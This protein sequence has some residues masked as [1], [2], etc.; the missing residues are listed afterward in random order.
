M[1][2][3]SPRWTN[4]GTVA[5]FETGQPNQVLLEFAKRF[6]QAGAAPRCLDIGCGAARNALPLAALG[7]RVSA[8]DL[9]APMLEGA[10]R[11][12]AGATPQPAVDLVR[13]PMA[14]LPFADAGFDLIVAHGIWNLAR[15]GVEFRAA[16]AEA[17]RVARPGAGLFVFTFSR[18]TLGPAAV[19]DA[20]ESFVFSSWN[21]EPQCFLT[22]PE[23]L[24][25]LASAG[26]ERADPGPLTEYNVPRPGE[27]RAGGP[28]VI[29]EGTF[30]K[31]STVRP[32]SLR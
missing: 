10:K 21:G 9:S 15:S 31:Q 11:R 26:F 8:T 2:E 25:E 29:Y 5:G 24:R 17:A 6:A 30:V 14:P 19:P 28:P 16:V 13:A 27:L 12:I 3:V 22:E 18:H 20:G 32:V 23:L 7:F 4:A 1:S